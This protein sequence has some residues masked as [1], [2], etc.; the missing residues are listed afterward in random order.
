MRC[1]RCN[2]DR[3][4][5]DDERGETICRKCGMVIDE[6]IVEVD[7]TGV[8]QTGEK[9]HNSG[10]ISFSIH[11][12]GLSTDISSDYKDNSGKPIPKSSQALTN[13][14][15]KTNKR[16]KVSNNM[17]KNL[18][19]AMMELHKL[20]DKLCITDIVKEDAA[21]IYRDVLQKNMLRGRSIMTMIS[22][23]LYVACRVTSTP[24]T[25]SEIS[26]ASNIKKIDIAKCYRLIIR[27]LEI[28]IPIVDIVTCNNKIG[29]KLG[30]PESIKRR[31]LKILNSL[32]RN[33]EISGKDPM[34][35]CAATL[36]MA[37]VEN[38]RNESQ[39]QLAQA[40]GVTD[41]TVRNKYKR[42]QE[43]MSGVE[44]NG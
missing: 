40:S 11:D 28:K 1:K 4:L 13:S 26:V 33:K 31:S 41:V 23:S 44:N 12:M 39:R 38:N 14:L 43:I 7:N 8:Q 2:S 9:T 20:T 22:A 27:D 29:N 36:Y 10:Q 32:D 18:R 16:L 25:L 15:K 35:I 37:C 17:E 34:G 3:M 19:Q 6:R 5:V 24:K 42:L 30:L 21:K